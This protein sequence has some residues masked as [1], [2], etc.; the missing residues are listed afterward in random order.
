MFTNA[1]DVDLDTFDRDENPA[2]VSAIT[3]THTAPAIQNAGRK[4]SDT[5]R[6]G[7]RLKCT[8]GSCSHTLEWSPKRAWLRI[9]N[10]FSPTVRSYHSTGPAQ[11]MTAYA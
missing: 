4:A 2:L 3:M 1:D 5:C 7:Y 8:F 10:H 6:A 9:C 11:P